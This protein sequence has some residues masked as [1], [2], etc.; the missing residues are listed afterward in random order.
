VDE[1]EFENGEWRHH[2]RTQ[3]IVVVVAFEPEPDEASSE[4]AI[5]LVIVTVWR[6]K[7]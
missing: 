2:V 6:S 7:P 4:D 1:A 3:K 5:E